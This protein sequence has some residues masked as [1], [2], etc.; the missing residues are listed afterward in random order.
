ML[1]DENPARCVPH[2]INLLYGLE[3]LLTEL[4][5][6]LLASIVGTGLAVESHE[7]TEVELGLLEELDLADV[8]L[9]R[10][11]ATG[12]PSKRPNEF[13]WEMRRTYVLERVDPLGSLLNLAA[14]DLGNELGGE[15]S[16]GAAGSLALDD[17][18]HLFADGTNLGRSRIGGLLDLVGAALSE[19][20][21]EKTE[22]VVVGGL[23]RDVGLDQGLPLAD[24]RAELVGGEVKAV[25]VGQAVLA[26]DFV[27]TELDLAEGVV[28]VLLEIG[29]GDLDDTALESIVRVLETGGS[30]DQGL[31]D[32]ELNVRIDCFSNTDFDRVI[33][34]GRGRRAY[35]LTLKGAGA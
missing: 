10:P 34:A 26:L 17:L 35:S 18:G 7:S 23:D 1:L 30:V 8:D 12:M 20:D 14:N 3:D 5:L 16:E 29:E 31:A 6:N 4:P 33:R 19:S 11:L 13:D 28:L 32:T 15:L 27:D 25:E 24:E 9:F 21:G 22:K 2:S